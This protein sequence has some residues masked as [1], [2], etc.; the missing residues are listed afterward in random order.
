[1]TVPNQVEPPVKT[2]PTGLGF[3]CYHM[4]INSCDT[5]TE[6]HTGMRKTY[7]TDVHAHLQLKARLLLQKATYK[8][9][10]LDCRMHPEEQTKAT[11]HAASHKPGFQCYFVLSHQVNSSSVQQVTHQVHLATFRKDWLFDSNV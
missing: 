9:E 1:M 6:K 10:P 4:S 5:P 3:G 11:Q 7:N 2:Q 8:K